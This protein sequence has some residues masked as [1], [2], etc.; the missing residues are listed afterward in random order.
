MSLEI[1]ALSDRPELLEPLEAMETSWPEFMLHD[2]MAD[3]YFEPAVLR[4]FAD[5]ILVG[6]DGDGA[7]AAKGY[8]IPFP[9]WGG[10][11][12]DDGWDGVVV[13]GV[14]AA[15]A[16]DEP[17]S[18]SA[19]EISVRG[20]LQGR[21]HSSQMLR[22]MIDNARARGFAAL[23]LRPVETCPARSVMLLPNRLML[24]N[25]DAACPHLGMKE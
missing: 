21:G 3:I 23:F 11:M 14:T 9:A 20:D 17:D 13:R 15:V 7:V 12:R 24:K 16:G 8:S 18:V 4:M 2:P 19:I 5:Y 25:S 1:V 6:L 22:A 10:A